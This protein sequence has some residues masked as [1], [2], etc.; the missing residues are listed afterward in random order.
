MNVNVGATGFGNDEPESF[1]LVEE[2]HVAAAHRAA[3]LASTAAAKR[4][5]TAATAASATTA[6]E[7]RLCFSRRKIDAVHRRHLHAALTLR[8]ITVDGRSLRQVWRR[9]S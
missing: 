1:L 8:N 9:Q 2:L 3:R 6:A 5:W 4:T 7:R